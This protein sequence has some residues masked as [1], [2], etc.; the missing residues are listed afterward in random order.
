MKNA[1]SNA[2]TIPSKPATG[3][4]RPLPLSPNL[5][6]VNGVLVETEYKHKGVVRFRPCRV[7]LALLSF[8]I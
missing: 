8:N 2:Q 5:R 1:V 7:V 4:Y 6:G 3:R